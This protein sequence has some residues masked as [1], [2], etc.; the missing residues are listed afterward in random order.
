MGAGMRLRTG[1]MRDRT[2]ARAAFRLPA[3]LARRHCHSANRRRCVRNGKPSNVYDIKYADGFTMTRTQECDP[4]EYGGTN[5]KKWC[6]IQP[7]Q[8]LRLGAAEG[9]ESDHRQ[10]GFALERQVEPGARADLATTRPNLKRFE[11][12]LAQEHY[13]LLKLFTIRSKTGGCIVLVVGLRPR[14]GSA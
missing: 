5:G 9:S 4:D 11:L 2:S 14:H 7:I 6:I 13:Y 10:N 12:G 3:R 1:F 8:R